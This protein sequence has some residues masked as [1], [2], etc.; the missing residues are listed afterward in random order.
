MSRYARL[1]RRS[2][3]E[4]DFREA[5]RARLNA[6]RVDDPRGDR[7]ER[8]KLVLEHAKHSQSCYAVLRRQTDQ[9]SDLAEARLAKLTMARGKADLRRRGL[10]RDDEL[11][12]LARYRKDLLRYGDPRVEKIGIAREH[13]DAGGMREREG[14]RQRRIDRKNDDADRRGEDRERYNNPLLGRERDRELRTSDEETDERRGEREQAKQD[15]K[16]AANAEK[17]AD[18]EDAK[19]DRQLDKNAA[20]EERKA[21][22]K[23][24]KAADRAAESE[25]RSQELKDERSLDKTLNQ[26]ESRL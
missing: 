21:D 18:R 8:W 26:A 3:T 6:K 24:D 13:D 19:L 5:V 1:D 11:K 20:K 14:T 7:E 15:E 17:K 23:A 4:G 2:D 12:E 10:I 16:D 22:T 25:A 9:A